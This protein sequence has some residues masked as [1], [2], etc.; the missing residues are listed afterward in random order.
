MQSLLETSD[1]RHQVIAINQLVDIKPGLL[2]SPDTVW[3]GL[4][5]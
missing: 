2:K 3:S 1:R 4:G 5:G